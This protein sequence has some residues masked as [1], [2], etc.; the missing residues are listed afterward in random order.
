MGYNTK[1]SP[2]RLDNIVYARFYRACEKRA[3]RGICMHEEVEPSSTRSTTDMLDKRSPAVSRNGVYRRKSK[4][5]RHVC[6]RLDSSQALWRSVHKLEGLSSRSH[7]LAYSPY[8]ASP[9]DSR[10]DILLVVYDIRHF[11]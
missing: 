2:V 11:A 4:C 3:F 7:A 1:V 8:Q 9:P 5:A 6:I 10:E